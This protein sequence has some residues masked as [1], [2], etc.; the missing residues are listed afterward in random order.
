MVE[1]HGAD[2]TPADVHDASA[3]KRSRIGIVL[4]VA[5]LAFY[6]GYVLLNAFAPA[7]IERTQLFGVNLAVNYGLALIAVAF[8]LAVAYDLICRSLD[9]RPPARTEDR[10]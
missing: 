3:G 1:L 9:A 5:Y 7:T 10:G 4:F 6:A 8:A 2:S